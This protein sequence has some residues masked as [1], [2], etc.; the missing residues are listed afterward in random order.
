MACM[1]QHE[2]E[3][4]DACKAQ[5][6]TVKQAAEEVHAD[7]K[8]DA[9]KLCQGVQP[10]G[11]RIHACLK[12]HEAEVSPTCQQAMAKMKDLHEAI[13]PGCHPDVEKLCKD[14]QPG[15][16]R[17]IACLN[18]HRAE[19]SPQCVAN[20]DKQQAKKAAGAPPAK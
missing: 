10:G 1:K 11:G 15:G 8:A 4:S 19:L 9:G 14:V 2:A 18:S 7:C 12:S 16:G 5:R 13:H 3:L 17:I 20:I 6:A